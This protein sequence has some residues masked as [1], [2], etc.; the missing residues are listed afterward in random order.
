[1]SWIEKQPFSTFRGFNLT[2][3]KIDE[4]WMNVTNLANQ[5]LWLYQRST[6]CYEVKFK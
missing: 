4:A 5:T 3:L 2:E 1:M 6:D